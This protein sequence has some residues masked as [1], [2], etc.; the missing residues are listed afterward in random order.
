MRKK[1]VLLSLIVVSAI[2]Y[3]AQSQNL[4]FGVIL[5]ENGGG[6]QTRT[7]VDSPSVYQDAHTLY[8]Y[9]GCD[10]ATLVLVDESG[11]VVYSTAIAEGTTQIVLPSYLV[12]E[13]ELR[14]IR[15]GYVFYTEIDL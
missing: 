13:Y 4:N 15:G 10:N 12:G 6:T 9:S 2:S 5:D 1:I 8:L 11:S 14:I 7:L 3:V